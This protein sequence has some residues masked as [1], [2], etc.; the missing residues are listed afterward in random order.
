MC[1]DM[2]SYG[3]LKTL[4]L[5]PLGT[6]A[7]GLIVRGISDYVGFKHVTDAPTK[8]GAGWRC[9]MSAQWS[10]RSLMIDAANS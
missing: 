8:T 7:L 5:M 9:G 2:E 4:Q 3:F 6:P 10:G 1:V